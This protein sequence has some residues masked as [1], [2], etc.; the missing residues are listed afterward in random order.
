[1]K[2]VSVVLVFMFLTFGLFARDANVLPMGTGRLSVMPGY[3]FAT[4]E[5]D[6]LRNLDRFD[7]VSMRFF[8][9]GFGLEYGVLSWITASAQWAPGWI[10]WSDENAAADNVSELFVG[11]KML[12]LGERAPF[13]SGEFRFA[14]APGVFIPLTENQEF[15]IG[16]RFYF[17]WLFNRNFFVNLY[18]ETL[19]FPED[20]DYS[21]HFGIGSVFTTPIANG[22][23][24]TLGLPATYRYLSD[25]QHSLGISPHVSLFFTDT[26]LPLEFKFQ[27]DFPLWGM[28][29]TAWHSVSMQIRFYFAFGR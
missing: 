26:P 15:A 10:P 8:G 5:Y 12:L 17:D 19:F 25:R 23:D 14:A 18:N 27:Y 21:L 13:E 16:A 4:G 1:M 28:N 3:S 24:F 9:L 20:A 2:K 22:L 11:V 7:E 6:D 29:S